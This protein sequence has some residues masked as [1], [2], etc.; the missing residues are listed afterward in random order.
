MHR[1]Q[2]PERVECIAQSENLLFIPVSSHAEEF[3]S[4]EYKWLIFVT[5]MHSWN[6]KTFWCYIRWG[7]WFLVIWREEGFG[8]SHFLPH[9]SR[10]RKGFCALG[11]LRLVDEPVIWPPQKR[12]GQSLTHLYPVCSISGT[13]GLESN[14]WARI[15][16]YGGVSGYKNLC[17]NFNSSLALWERM[18]WTHC[19]A[20]SMA[21]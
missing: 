7:S 3:L 20:K 15:H 6:G 10:H 2:R 19:I 14:T 5:N 18:K 8:W 17:E 16:H 4:Q 9:F 21:T 11:R 1:H 12:R 13:F